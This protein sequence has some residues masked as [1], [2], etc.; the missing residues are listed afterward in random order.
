MVAG[1]F[2]LDGKLDL[3]VA[4]PNR[5]QVAVLSG[6][7]NGT[8]QS[9]VPYGLDDPNFVDGNNMLAVADLNGD[10]KPDLVMANL[11]SNHVTVLP[12]LGDGTFPT[13]KSYAAG[14]EPIWVVVADFNGDGKPDVAAAD[15]GIPGEVALLLGNGDGTLQAPPLYRSGSIPDSLLLADL[16]G[17]GKLDIITASRFG[18]TAAGIGSSVAM[19]EAGMGDSKRQRSG[20]LPP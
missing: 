12:G 7:G 17:D 4:T 10:G 18:P 3:A 5:K 6:F 8:F 16:N 15:D 20:R 9:A 2:N 11:S 19:L 1:D 13:S 14:P